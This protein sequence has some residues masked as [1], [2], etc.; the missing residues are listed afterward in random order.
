MNLILTFLELILGIY[1]HWYDILFYFTSFNA[2][3]QTLRGRPLMVMHAHLGRICGELRFPNSLACIN[4]DMYSQKKAIETSIP[5][6]CINL[7]KYSKK[8]AIETSI[9]F[10]CISLDKYSKKKAIETSNPLLVLTLISIPKRKPL[11]PQF[12]CLY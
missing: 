12:P 10:A 8:K 6:A 7:D 1:E 2:K 4:L 11:K 3:S 5:F 9:P